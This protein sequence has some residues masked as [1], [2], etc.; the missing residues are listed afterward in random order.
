M[1][2]LQESPLRKDSMNRQHLSGMCRSLRRSSLKTACALDEPSRY[3]SVNPDEACRLDEPFAQPP[4]CNYCDGSTKECCGSPCVKSPECEANEFYD[5]GLYKPCTSRC[6]GM[7]CKLSRGC[8]TGICSPFGKCDYPRTV[9]K[10]P[11]RAEDF[12]GRRGPGSLAHAISTRV[13]QNR[14]TTSPARSFR[15]I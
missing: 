4:I 14:G 15:M 2:Q 10:G 5:W 3:N 8:K 13:L 1:R 12:V 11:M 7:A 9:S 6:L